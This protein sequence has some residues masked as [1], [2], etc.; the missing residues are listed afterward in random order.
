M[1][2]EF[3]AQQEA[4]GLMNNRFYNSIF[5]IAEAEAKL[6]LCTKIDEEI[7]TETMKSIQLMLFQY[8]ENIKVVAKPSEITLEKFTHILE[9]TEAGILI[10]ELC[11]IACKQDPQIAAYLGANWTMAYS[12]RSRTSHK[13][14][15]YTNG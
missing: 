2:N 7:A 9:N 4:G 1:L 13:K 3:W 11:R 15:A 14:L 10:N 6:Q 12:T 5:K 8:A